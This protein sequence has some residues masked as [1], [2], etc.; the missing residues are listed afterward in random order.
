MLDDSINLLEEIDSVSKI[1]ALQR[2]DI[3]ELMKMMGNHVVLALKIERTSVWLFNHE[4]DAIVSIGEYDL[5]GNK[6]SKNTTLYLKDFPS[7]FAAIKQNK[8]VLAENIYTHPET[9]EFTDAYS[10]PNDIISL[11]DIPLRISGEL[12]GVMCFEKTGKQERKFTQKEQSFAFSVSLVFASNLEAR[13]R[14]VAQQKLEQALAEKELLIKEINHRVKNNFAILVSMLRLSKMQDHKFNPANVLD[15]FEQRILSMVKVQDMLFQSGNYTSVDLAKYVEELVN[16]FRQSHPELD[17]AI[18]CKTDVSNISLPSKFAIHLG[19]VITE[20][21]LN[22]IKYTALNNPDG[23]M[24]I[25]LSEIDANSVLL[26]IS[27][28]GDGFDFEEKSKLDTL[29]LLLIKDLVDGIISEVSFP[30]KGNCA[31]EFVIA[32][33]S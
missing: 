33:P 1:H 14:R 22:F 13:H 31:Y 16:E 29:G 25:A 6:F 10:Q 26:K 7:Y 11:M 3:D 17:D 12:V 19:L 4:K 8:V 15:E 24:T 20:I 30:V 2:D 18:F 28:N 32:L 27:D 23:R 5:R 21:F 9:Q